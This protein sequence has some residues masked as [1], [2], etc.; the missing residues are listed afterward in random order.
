MGRAAEEVLSRVNLIPASASLL[1]AAGELERKSLRSLDALHVATAL[2]VAPI[3]AFLTYDRRQADAANAAGLV[4]G[5]P[6]VD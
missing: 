6:A 2:A 1:R 5:S 3:D 4:V